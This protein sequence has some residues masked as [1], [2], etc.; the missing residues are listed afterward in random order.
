MTIKQQIVRA[1]E[2]YK[3]EGF[4]NVVRAS[5]RKIIRLIRH[6]SFFNDLFYFYYKV[7]KSSRT[8]KFQNNDYRYFI[9][10][11]NHTWRSE[12]AVE[13]PIIY[14]M[15]KKYR[16]KNILEVG[17][18]LSRYFPVNHKIIDKYE[19]ADNITNI[20]VVD[21]QTSKKYDFIFAISTLEHVGWDEIPKSSTKILDAIENLQKLIN[22]GGRIVIT[23]P[24][25]QNPYLDSLLL[26][27]KIQFSKRYCLKRVSKDNKWIE[28]YWKD[29]CNAKYN[30]PFP[31]ANGLIIGSFEK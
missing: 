15:V 22:T 25:G 3:E 8:F 6:S 16:G 2:I 4:D 9:N 13:I 28:V 14:E 31:Y 27:E 5:G 26:H 12:R 30:Y 21:F 24:L 18:V 7:F 17:N 10:K 20:D 19:K 11:N 1:K 29:I 23:L